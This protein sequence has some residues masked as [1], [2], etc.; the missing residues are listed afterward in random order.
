M[1]QTEVLSHKNYWFKKTR[2]KVGKIIS[3]CINCILTE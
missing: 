3:D 2:Q 1:L